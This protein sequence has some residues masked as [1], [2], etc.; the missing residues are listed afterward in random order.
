MTPSPRFVRANLNDHPSTMSIGDNPELG[1]MWR[2]WIQPADRWGLV[3]YAHS[4]VLYVNAASVPYREGDVSIWAPG[5]RG[6]HQ[7]VGAGTSFYSARFDLPGTMAPMAVPTLVHA[8]HMEAEFRAACVT[9]GYTLSHAIAVV[10]HFLW[11]IASPIAAFRHAEELY[12]AEEWVRANLARPFTI[13]E[14]AEQLEVSQRTLLRLFR[15]QHGL[16]VK[17]YVTQ[18]RAR[19]AS[20]LLSTTELPFKKIAARVGVPDPHAFNKLVRSSVGISPTELRLRSQDR[21]R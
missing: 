8:P 7:S 20:R 15:V 19:E 18:T 2:D 16:S 12:R 21:L 9:A 10:W 4:G 6:G 17:G 3:Y 14:M 5:M 11:Q 1:G 13:S